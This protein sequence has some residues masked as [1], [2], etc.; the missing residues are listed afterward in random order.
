MSVIVTYKNNDIA[1]FSNTE[2]TLKTSGKFMEDDVVISENLRLQNKTVAA[3]TATQTVTYNSESFV[4]S[5]F[6]YTGSLSLGSG[7]STTFA[8]GLATK[9]NNFNPLETDIYY[10]SGTVTLL[11]EDS[12]VVQTITFDMNEFQFNKTNATSSPMTGFTYTGSYIIYRLNMSYYTASG[13]S[14]IGTFVNGSIVKSVVFDLDFYSPAYDGLNQVIITNSSSSNN[15]QSKTITPSTLTQT[16]TPDNGYNAL[17][18]VIINPIP[19]NYIVPTG[20][21]NITTNGTHDVSNYAS[22]EVSITPTVN[23]Q[24][25]TVTPSTSQQTI[26]ADSGYDGLGTITINAI[27]PTKAAATYNVS[28]SNQTISANQ[29]LSGAQTIRGVT[30]SGISAA[31]I[32]AGTIV[33]VG[34]SANA[35]R[36]TSVTGTFTSDANATAADIV[37]G[38]SGY[39][40]GS[41]IDGSLVLQIYYT[42]SSEPSSN[43]GNNGDLYFQTVE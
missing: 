38:K 13:Y 20:T 1:S 31:N 10:I 15:F 33:T 21:L 23:N 2:K 18:Q 25:K 19:S 43:L 27:S 16:I 36:I 11:N 12:Q 28:S 4:Y 6:N 5:S 34:D 40:N 42:G 14:I 17:Y 32:K 26:T 29:W 35:S 9:D 37:L 24:N 41:K 30:T 8:Q 7:G 3:N 22:A 39:V